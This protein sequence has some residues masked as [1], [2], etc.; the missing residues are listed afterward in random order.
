MSLFKIKQNR[1]HYL[2][3]ALGIHESLS[4]RYHYLHQDKPE[5]QGVWVLKHH[6][7]SVSSVIDEKMARALI[8]SYGTKCE[9]I[10][11]HTTTLPDNTRQHNKVVISETHI[12][13][14][15]GGTVD[16]RLASKKHKFWEVR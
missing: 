5:L 14:Y 6:D 4:V 12:E 11:A 8:N 2:R 3:W 9:E 16:K 7:K 15:I 13:S 10:V 1:T